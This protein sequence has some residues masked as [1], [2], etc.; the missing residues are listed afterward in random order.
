MVTSNMQKRNRKMKFFAFLLAMFTAFVFM[1]NLSTNSAYLQTVD[2]IPQ[3]E[4]ESYINKYKKKG[5]IPGI[6]VSVVVGDSEKYFCY[7]ITDVENKTSVTPHTKFELGSN[8]KAFTALGIL[9]L[10]SEGK[11]SLED[12]ISKFYPELDFYYNDNK[13]DITIEQL[14][15][16]TSGIPYKTISYIKEDSSENA[17]DNLI[18]SLDGCVLNRLPGEKYEYATVNYDILGGVVQKTSGKKYEEYIREIIFAPL[19]MNE[20]F[21]INEAEQYQEISD[22]FVVEFVK[23]R[24][25]ETPDY[26]GNIPAGY[27]LSSLVDMSKWIKLQNGLSDSGDFDMQLIECSHDANRTVKSDNNGNSYSAGWETYQNGV[28][29]EF[30]HG[31]T[32]QSFS[33]YLIFRPETQTGVVVLCNTNSSYTSVIA[34]GIMNIISGDKPLEQVKND[35]NIMIDNISIILLVLTVVVTVTFIVLLFRKR[36]S[37]SMSNFHSNKENIVH[38]TILI[39]MFLSITVA[40]YFLPNIFMGGVDWNFV[41][42][43]TPRSLHIALCALT[44]LMVVCF[45]SMT[46]SIVFNVSDEFKIGSLLCLSVFSGLGNAVIIFSINYAI[47]VDNK[48]KVKVLFYLLLGALLYVGGQH[49]IRNKLICFTNNAVFSKRMHIIKRFMGTSYEEIEKLGNGKIQAVLNNDAEIVSN[50]ANTFVSAITGIVTLLCCFMYLYFCNKY[51]LLITF[52]VLLIIV[53]IYFIYGRKANKIN[54][55][56]RD[57]QNVYY[58]YIQDFLD[59]IKELV[60]NHRKGEMF[61]EDMEQICGQYKYQKTKSGKVYAN[62]F[63]VGE[64]LFTIVIACTAFIIPLVINN[65]PSSELAGYIFILLYMTGP[66]NIVLDSIPNILNIKICWN[67]IDELVSILNKNSLE[68]YNGNTIEQKSEKIKLEF[69]NL[70]FCYDA[71]DETAF[72][73]GPINETLESGEIIFITGG[74]GSGKSTFCKLITGLYNATFGKILLNDK[75]IDSYH[76]RMEY[77]AIFSDFHL[78]ERLY[79]IDC[80]KNEKQIENYLKMFGLYKKVSVVDG[81]FTTINLSTGQKKRL[82]LIVSLLEDKDIYIFD[83]W[84]ADQDPIFRRYFYTEILPELKSRGKCII[85]VTHDDKYFELCDKHYKFEYGV[86]TRLR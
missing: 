61:V 21:F 47:Y 5:R 68:N 23:Q 74:N 70:I 10:E 33:S 30:K 29:G 43:W 82:A 79:G 37:L 2:D 32:N 35:T 14:L 13:V 19:G 83:E 72:K 25:F 57:I 41:F 77:T 17:I 8:T 6:A 22:G 20:T 51:A 45:T 18:E 28:G 66:I 73:I 36:K 38:I 15:H 34:N 40:V 55:S 64:L 62:L 85:A 44:F 81:K 4:I 27:C 76:L 60:L 24:T 31:G 80:S 54:D 9:K 11:I 1:I 49:I 59:G 46:A 3:D 84:A 52:L 65:I 12:N 75:E 7:G 50:F 63:V 71:K 58:K 56:A 78:F 42:E 48:E 53:T 67:R 86:L 16:H 39:L 69:K 26:F